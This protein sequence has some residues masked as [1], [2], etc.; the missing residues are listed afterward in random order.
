MMIVVYV[1]C[2]CAACIVGTIGGLKLGEWLES[3]LW[4]KDDIW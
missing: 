4:P 1:V 3:K 2:F